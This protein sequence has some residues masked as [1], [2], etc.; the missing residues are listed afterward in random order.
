MNKLIFNNIGRAVLLVLLQVVI[1]KHI[2]LSFGDFAYM[3]FFIYPLIIFLVPFRVPKPLLILSAFV[4]G[5][6]IDMFYDSPGVHASALV[7]TSYMRGYILN[8][9]EPY[10]GY[11]VDAGPNTNDMGFQWFFIYSSILLGLHMIFYFSIEHFSFVYFFE[12][13]MN[14][15][16][17]FIA[18]FVIMLLFIIIFKPK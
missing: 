1:F 10:E 7:F 13:F 8:A 4:I 16:S 14:A 6:T 12:I 2:S 5:I 11:N 3:H 15:I 9:L 17:S 18:S